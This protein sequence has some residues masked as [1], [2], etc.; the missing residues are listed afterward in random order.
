[1]KNK[2]LFF[3]PLFFVI[4]AVV[5]SIVSFLQNDRLEKGYLHSNNATETT[6]YGGDY[7]AV[8]GN[9]KDATHIT[10]LS[11]DQGVQLF[12]YD[13]NAILLESYVYQI[14]PT[15]ETFD[16]GI[17]TLTPLT[18]ESI[19][20]LDD[21]LFTVDLIDNQ[22]YTISLLQETGSSNDPIDLILVTLDGNAYL[23]KQTMENVVYTSLIL[24]VTSLLIVA[25]IVKLKDEE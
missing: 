14:Y 11:T 18:M 23:V 21:Y 1:M 22:E 24:G 3:I 15:G 12:F 6:S 17:V 13:E 7:F 2:K 4:L 10:T 25:L 20:E 8:L 16:R 9:I 5:A 19:D